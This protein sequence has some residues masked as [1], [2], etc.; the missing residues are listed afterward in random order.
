MR[1]GRWAVLLLTGMVAVGC[2]TTDLRIAGTNQANPVALGATIPAVVLYIEVP[3]G[4]SL[5]LLGA[6]LLGD[7]GDT[8]VDVTLSRPVLQGDGSTLLGEAREPLIGA[9]VTVPEDGSEAATVG[10]LA[11]VTPAGPGRYIMTGLRLQYRLDGGP[12]R[13]L[14]GDLTWII[15]ADDPAPATC[16]PEASPEE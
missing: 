15:C 5:E 9:E 6:E 8:F 12:S 7:T 4:R 11:D 13:S 1:F 3:A 16:D 14:V 10:I 2:G